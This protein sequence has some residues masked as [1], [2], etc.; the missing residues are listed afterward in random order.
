[1]R[2]DNARF[3]MACGTFAQLPACT[4]PEIAF[5]GRSNV[6][7]SSLLN[8]LL[9]RKSLARVS[10]KPGKTITINFYALDGV[11]LTDLPGY[12]YAKVAQSEK[13]RWAEMMEGYFGSER[14]IRLVVQLIDMRHPPSADDFSMLDYLAQMQYPFV[15]ALTKCDKLN[16]MERAERT[17][18]L[19]EELAAYPEILKIP[20][21][22]VTGEGTEELRAAI[23]AAV[24][25]GAGQT[26]QD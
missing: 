14:D 7:K 9:N 5:A 21:S 1:M 4:A 15:I 20:F 22:A 2:F 11:R 6:G 10:A 13:K 25:N 23:A 16:K 8:K 19:K 26:D 12:G 18:A 17:Q 3:E 24:E